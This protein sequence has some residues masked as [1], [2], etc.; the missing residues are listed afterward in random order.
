MMMFFVC[1]LG[2]TV[3]TAENVDTAGGVA[4]DVVGEGNGVDGRPGCAA[5]LVAHR[6]QDG[7]PALRVGPGVL[8]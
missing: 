2:C 7:E 1:P 6:E 4:E 5:I 8:H 3:V